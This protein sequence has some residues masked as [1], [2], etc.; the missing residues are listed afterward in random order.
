MSPEEKKRSKARPYR[1]A[2]VLA[3][4]MFLVV[5]PEVQEG[6]SMEPT[7]EDGQ[8]FVVSK[9][10]RY[11]AKRKAPERDKLVILDKQYS[12][13]AGADDN[14][15]TRVIAVPGDTVEA[16]DGRI[17]VNDEEYETKDMISGT[18]KDLKKTKLKGNQIYVLCDNR[19][20]DSAAY[21][22]RNPKLGKDGLVDMREIKGNVLLR[23]WPI[24]DFGLMTKK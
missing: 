8:V 20:E 23:I 1:I 2:I 3:L 15:I 6:G 7:I 18:T 22:S 17:Y 21:D 13:N 16:K 10:A 4:I 9:M 12:L 11:S 24:S 14:I 19:D 5:A